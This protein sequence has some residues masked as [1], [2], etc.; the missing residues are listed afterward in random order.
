MFFQNSVSELVQL[1]GLLEFLH[2]K[3][4]PGAK[5]ILDAAAYDSIAKDATIVISGE[6]RADF[7]SMQGKLLSELS[8]RAEE[9]GVQLVVIAGE[10]TADAKAWAKE[11]NIDVF[12]TSPEIRDHDERKAKAVENYVKTLER[13]LNKYFE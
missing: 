6:G 12:E 9:N 7:Q 13:V 4:E 10:A 3:L 11:K 8:R 5:A 1:D 2:A